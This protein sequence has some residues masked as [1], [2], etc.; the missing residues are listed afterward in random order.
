MTTHESVISTISHRERH[1]SDVGE[2]SRPSD[3]THEIFGHLPDGR[4][5]RIF[6]LTNRNGLRARVTEYGA[7]LVSMETP[8][9]AGKSADL[10]LG[11][12]TLTDWLD[13]TA[14]LGA[15]C[16]RFG[17]RIGSGKFTLDGKDH[18][19]WQERDPFRPK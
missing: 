7:I 10:T 15:T 13:N 18:C 11:Y 4:E 1:L 2:M 5:V 14:Y 16:G 17:N 9:R 8:D 12:D 6:T 3:V 19:S